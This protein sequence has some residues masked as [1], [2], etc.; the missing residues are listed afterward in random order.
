MDDSNILE[1]LG[2]VRA[3]FRAQN[4]QTEAAVNQGFVAMRQEMR[5]GLDRQHDQIQSGLAAMHTDFGVKFVTMDRFDPV[6]KLVYG[7]VALAL[8][9]IVTAVLALVLRSK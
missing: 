9:A 1:E 8:A 4:M 6:Q 3:E 5:A 2:R 7:G